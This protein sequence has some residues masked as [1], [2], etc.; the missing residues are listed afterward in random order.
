[1]AQAAQGFAGGDFTNRLKV[2]SKDEIG[3]LASSMNDMAEQLHPYSG[4]ERQVKSGLRSC[5]PMKN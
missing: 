5:R 2:S 1:M 3:S 4:L